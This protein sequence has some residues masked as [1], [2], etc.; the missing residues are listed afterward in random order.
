M[1]LH[2]L[3]ELYDRLKDQ[4]EYLVAPRGYSLQKIAFKVVLTLEG[5]LFD[6][7]DMRHREGTRLVPRQMIVPGGA[8]PSGSG[9]NPCFL[10]DNY[11]YMLGKPR[12]D[13]P[14]EWVRLRFERFRCEHF[15]R[16]AEINSRGYR[17][18]CSFLRAWDPASVSDYP[19][20]DELTSGFGVFQIVGEAALVS[21][22]HLIRSWWEEASVANSSDTPTRQCLITGERESI[23]KIH[24][25]K[26]KGVIGNVTPSPL[27][28]FNEAAYES[29][30]LKQSYNA[31]ISEAVAF[32]YTTALN[33]LLD[34]PQS[35]RHRMRVG[36][37][38]V[39]FWTD[40]PSF[41]ED[42]FGEI[43]SPGSSPM[44]FEESQDEAVRQKLE[45]FL[46]ALR[47][48]KEASSEFDQERDA[49]SF[50]LLGLSPNMGRI[51][52]RFFHRSTVAELLGKLRAHFRDIRIEARPAKGKFRGDPEFPSLQSLLDQTCPKKKKKLDR[53][54]IPPILAGPLLR[55][56]INGAPYPRSLFDA[57]IRRLRAGHEM[58]Y[59]RA[60]AI[61]GYLVRNLKQEV[62]M[63]LDN[64][65]RDPGY[66]LGRL[67]AVL[68]KTQKDALGKKINATI[69]DR[70]YSAASATLG[71]V[72][73]R[74][75]RTYQHHLAKLAKL[76]GGRGLK[77]NREKLIQEVL[78]PLDH[79]PAHL[80][81]ADQGL[82]ALGYYQQTQSFYRSKAEREG[83]E[84]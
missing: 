48:G 52:V 84:G 57:I 23:A 37:S 38:T 65:R 73:P 8:K 55:A 76:E 67:F 2:A 34:G 22:D 58:N 18:V 4:H 3:N 19:I 79:F 78:E 30:G 50:Y 10:W 35:D 63:S 83:S 81:L 51:S 53:E 62:S 17:A 82:F 24:Q 70:F 36:D 46:S 6:I 77:V 45:V 5:E 47:T 42:I 27:V 64:T 33:A 39:V 66:R 25:P 20:L 54:K 7:Q 59:T 12:D 16:E 28:G 14:G 32:R 69:R 41:T 1:I 44:S 31:P 80:G 15:A 75:L 49:T 29:Y 68:E 61:K 11:H 74:L 13:K 43:M 40:K 9:I 26:I 71:A 72:F 60:C 56:V 21:D